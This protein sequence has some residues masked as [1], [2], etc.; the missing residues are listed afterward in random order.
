M[1]EDKQ[2]LPC[3]SCGAVDY[4]AAPI[5]HDQA[6]QRLAAKTDI[7]CADCFIR[8]AIE[9]GCHVKFADLRPR[10]FNL[11]GRPR[12]WFDFFRADEA[13]RPPPDLL[14]TWRA[15]MKC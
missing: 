15:V 11:F 6:W 9:R 10:S 7:L 1:S 12:S 14:E 13:E 2:S 3:D 4:V 5:L 8:R